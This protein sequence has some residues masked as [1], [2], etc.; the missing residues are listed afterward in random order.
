[1]VNSVLGNFFISEKTSVKK[2]IFS[3]FLQ[4]QYV[5]LGGSGDNSLGL[6]SDIWKYFLKN[7]V[8]VLWIQQNKCYINLNAKSSLLKIM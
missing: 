6:C 4:D 3:S 7:I 5:L 1:M 8:L 2:T